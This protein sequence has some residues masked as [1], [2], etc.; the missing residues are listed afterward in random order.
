MTS[1]LDDAEP[2][3]TQP[4]FSFSLGLSCVFLIGGETKDT[5]PIALR[6]DSG[7]LM[8]MADRS[9]RCYHGVPRI[10]AQTFVKEQFTYGE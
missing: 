2:D 6:L 7:D 9:R 4:I 5:E 1:H 8:V 3:Q 10:I